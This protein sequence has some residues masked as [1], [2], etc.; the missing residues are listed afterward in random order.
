MSRL[1]PL[2]VS[3]S[4]TLVVIIFFI[5]S[6]V[7]NNA[8]RA[9]LDSSS[10]EVSKLKN[11]VKDLAGL[12]AIEQ[13]IIGIKGDPG[14]TGEKG[15]PGEKG[16][17][18]D[19]GVQGPQ[20]PQGVKGSKGD[21]GEQGAAGM[22]GYEVVWGS[23]VSIPNDGT[24]HNATIQCPSGKKLLSV[25]CNSAYLKAYVISSYIIKDYPNMGACSWKNEQT[26]TDSGYVVGICA[27]VQ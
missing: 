9:S 10:T 2:F 18:G 25:Q 24:N 8:L 6:L 21:K 20:G 5:V 14:P 27:N 1:N 7:T 3:A 12:I 11:E 23:T 19:Q 13:D 26:T 15:E 17:T 4:I 16:E 22:S